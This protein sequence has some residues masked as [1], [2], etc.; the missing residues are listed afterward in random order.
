VA[1]M[2]FARRKMT[3]VMVGGARVVW[4]FARVYFLRTFVVFLCEK[5]DKLLTSC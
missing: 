4:L 3:M 5:S 1:P 2:L